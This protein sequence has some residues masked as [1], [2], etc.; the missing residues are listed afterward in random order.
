[1]SEQLLK[2]M[3]TALTSDVMGKG[4]PKSEEAKEKERLTRTALDTGQWKLFLER[5]EKEE[6]VEHAETSNI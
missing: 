6:A 3:M 1:M 4:I 5:T 2:N